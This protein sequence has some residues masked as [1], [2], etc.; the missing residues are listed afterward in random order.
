MIAAYSAFAT[1]GTRARRTRIVRVENRSG[2]VLWE[3]QPAASPVMSPEKR[4]SWS[5]MMK[6]VVQRG[7]AAG[8]SAPSSTS[9]PA[10]RP[11]RRTTA[12]TSGSSATRPTSSP[13]SGWA[14]QAAEDQGQRAGR[15]ARRAG[16]DRLHAR[17]LRAPGP[18]GLAAARGPDLVEIDANGYK[19]T[20]FCPKDVHYIESFIPG[21]EPKA[22]CPVHSPSKRGW[23]RIRSAGRRRSRPRRH[24]R[25]ARP[26]LPAGSAARRRPLRTPRSRPAPARPSLPGGVM[27]GAGPPPSTQRP[28]R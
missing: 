19:S 7:T 14:R 13:A 27:G 3:P 17:G 24:R 20:P 18:R 23:D 11:A 21:T 2:D 10:A 15:R 1:L 26:G 25:M 5:S 28:P 8:R 6:D 16:V 12:P 9:P 4:G 22:F